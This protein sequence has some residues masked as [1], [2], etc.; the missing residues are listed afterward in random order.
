MVKQ[1]FRKTFRRSWHRKWGQSEWRCLVSAI[2]L[3]FSFEKD[4]LMDNNLNK[5]LNALQKDNLLYLA[6]SS[7][8]S[9]S[10][11]KRRSVVPWSEDAVI[12]LKYCSHHLR[13]EQF[14]LDSSQCLLVLAWSVA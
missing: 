14:V 4:M 9:L 1:D 8:S 5:S 2:K 12:S 3:G 13:M 6:G 10:H 7:S 11:K